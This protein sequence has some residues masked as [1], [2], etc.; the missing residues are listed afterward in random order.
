MPDCFSGDCTTM[1]GVACAAPN[2]QCARRTTQARPPRAPRGAPRSGRCRHGYSAAERRCGGVRTCGGYPASPWSGMTFP[3]AEVGLTSLGGSLDQVPGVLAV[4][5]VPDERREVGQ[6]VTVIS[7]AGRGRGRE[8]PRSVR[9][10]PSP[11]YAQP[12]GR[13]RHSRRPPRPA[14]GP[15]RSAPPMRREL[16]ARAR[17][18]HG[19]QAELVGGHGIR[20][21]FDHVED[22]AGHGRRVGPQVPLG[23]LTARDFGSVRSAGLVPDRSEIDAAVT[24]RLGPD[25]P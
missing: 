17:D 1:Y 22:L 24:V 5:V 2:A 12:S 23:A 15:S 6:V 11:T 14:D 7:L 10:S 8:R 25:P 13:A 19:G 16:R 21:A 3:A 20:L 18:R 9:R 4:L